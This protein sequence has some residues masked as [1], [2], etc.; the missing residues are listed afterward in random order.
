MLDLREHAPPVV[1]MAR[2]ALDYALS[3]GLARRH[4]AMPHLVCVVS[5]D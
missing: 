2:E 5:L 1:D 3:A 4:P